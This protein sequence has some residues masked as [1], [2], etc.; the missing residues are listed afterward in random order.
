MNRRGIVLVLVGS[1]VFA[2]TALAQ[3]PRVSVGEIK[4]KGGIM[5]RSAVIKALQA[6]KSVSLV[7]KDV[8]AGTARRAGI[9]LPKGRKEISTTLNIGAWVEGTVER[10]KKTLVANLAVLDAA[11]GKTLGVMSYDAPSMKVLTKTVR[12]E[13][14]TDLGELI[15]SGKVPG[16]AGKGADDGVASADGDDEGEGADD[17]AG[18][19][20]KRGQRPAARAAAPAAAADGDALAESDSPAATEEEPA[21]AAEETE[22]PAE[23]ASHDTAESEPS[24]ETGGEPPSP[25]SL[26]VGLVAFTRDFVYS[27][28]LSGLPQYDLG[29]GPSLAVGLTWYPAAHFSSGPA[30]NIGLDLRGQLAFGLDSQA[31]SDM[32]TFPTSSSAFGIGLRGRLPLGDSELGAM[33][34]YGQKSFTIGKLEP[35]GTPPPAAQPAMPSR[36]SPYVPSTSYSFLRIGVDARIALSDKFSVGGAFAFLPTF[37]TGVEEWFPHA[38]AAGLEGELKLGYTMSKALELNAGV[39]VQYFGLSFNPTPQE[40]Q[41]GNLTAGGA[42][43][44]YWSIALGMGWHF[45]P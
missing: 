43:D 9:T 10:E 39:G 19:A 6:E 29:L 34:G 27:D 41:M 18:E 3:P 37:S 26:N 1:L 20:P 13:L 25:L 23:T 7:S 22:A 31:T 12:S 15:K 4:G 5:V 35:A 11:T 40:Y 38:T 44:Q 16:A 14:F 30:A 32:T 17:T 36:T 42:E 33:F 2:S 24:A 45:S 28:D 21:A 8:V